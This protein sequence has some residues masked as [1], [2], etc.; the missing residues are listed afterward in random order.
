LPEGVTAEG[1]QLND[2]GVQAI[3][4]FN[5]QMYA[6]GGMSAGDTLKF[7]LS[8][9]PKE[10][11]AIS[12]TSTPEKSTNQNLLIGAGAVGFALILA[13]GWLYLRDRK[14]VEDDEQDLSDEFD[15]SDDVLDA[16]I[17]LDDLHRAKKIPD[18]AYQKRRA[19]LKEALKKEMGD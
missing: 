13:G 18:E 17:A 10:A 14:R 2:H 16:I 15:S 6:S 5:F 3:Q 9:A 7:T 1:S 19:E 4:G 11:S 8:G 12:T